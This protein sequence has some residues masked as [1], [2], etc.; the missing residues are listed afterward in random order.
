MERRGI[1]WWKTPPKSPDLNPIEM[2]WHEL[3]HFLRAIV[4]PKTKD[5]L[6]EGIRRFWTERVTATKCTTY[7]NH[8]QKV[9]P[10]VIQREGSASGE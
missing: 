9:V 8:L 5:E 7:I 10:L 2:L 4:K 1:N 3:K 6:L